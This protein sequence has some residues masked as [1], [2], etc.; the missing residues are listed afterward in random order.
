MTRPHLTISDLATREGVPE[1]TVYTWNSRRV[2]PRYLK[3]GRHVRYRLEDV[4]AW[5]DSRYA[6]DRLPA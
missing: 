6:E 3:I 5:E 2:G 1:S 4:I